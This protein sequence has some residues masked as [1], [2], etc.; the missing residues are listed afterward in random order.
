MKKLYLFSFLSVLFI[1][2]QAAGEI[3]ILQ[4]AYP[5]LAAIHL[6]LFI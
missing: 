2:Q 3:V 6:E 1:T 4:D 5:L